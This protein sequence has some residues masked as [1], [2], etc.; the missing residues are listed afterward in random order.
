ML[1]WRDYWIPGLH[2][3][4]G[5][6]LIDL[7]EEALNKTVN[8][9]VH[10]SGDWD[11]NMLR[12]LLREDIMELL[13][14]IK[15]PDPHLS[16]DIIDWLPNP[17]GEFTVKTAYTGVYGDH[18]RNISMFKKVWYLDIPHRLRAF[19]WLLAHEAILMNQ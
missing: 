3:L 6:A 2:S 15:A 5:F 19:L 18:N 4:E 17:A 11:W 14:T 7:D 10:E 1:F 8:F 12:D 9:Y 16:E 13:V